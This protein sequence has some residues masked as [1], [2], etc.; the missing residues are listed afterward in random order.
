[1]NKGIQKFYLGSDLAVAIFGTVLALML[2]ATKASAAGE[3]AP[4]EDF[5]ASKIVLMLFGHNGEVATRDFVT[6]YNRINQHKVRVKRHD[7]KAYEERDLTSEEFELLAN[8]IWALRD[9]ARIPNEFKTDLA[10]I[11]VPGVTRL[12]VSMRVRP[13]QNFTSFNLS[14][15]SGVLD[16]EIKAVARNLVEIG[17]LASS[18]ESE[19][20]VA[21]VPSGDKQPTENPQ[22]A[23]SGEPTGSPSN[24]FH[25]AF[26]NIKGGIS[27]LDKVDTPAEASQTNDNDLTRFSAESYLTSGYYQVPRFRLNIVGLREDGRS[28]KRGE[29][30]IGEF[31]KDAPWIHYYDTNEN[32]P[33]GHQRKLSLSE[34][35]RIDELVRGLQHKPSS[36]KTFQAELSNF[37]LDRIFQYN[38]SLSMRPKTSTGLNHFSI[39]QGEGNHSTVDEDAASLVRELLAISGFLKN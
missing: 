8:R 39:Q 11:G 27:D 7:S 9:R 18:H 32:N 5:E 26:E 36:P 23:S 22:D 6:V 3:S 1:M 12:T 30:T 15:G 35:Q 28:F 24:P 13:S 14:S 33:I 10:Q 21:G 16:P 2:F 34:C 20:K 31:G 37:G 38:L 25:K 29:I 17:G 19:T 4:P